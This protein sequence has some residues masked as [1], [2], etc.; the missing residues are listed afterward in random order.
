[1]AGLGQMLALPALAGLLALGLVFFVR[2]GALR[3]SAARRE[4]LQALSWT[5][6]PVAVFAL[7]AIPSLRL[8]ALRDSVPQADLTI[9]ITGTMWSWTYEYPDQN[10]L[11]FTAAMLTIPPPGESAVLREP[12][13][14]VV[15]LGKAV[16]IEAVGT[17]LIYSWA[18]PALGAKVT[19]LPGRTARTWFR[20]QTLGRYFGTCLELCAVPHSFAP[21]EV[22]VVSETRFAD[23]VADA[24]RRYAAA[25]LLTRL[26]RNGP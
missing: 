2:G 5:L 9:R 10:N 19:G 17:N 21:I 1:M 24:R 4:F 7:I 8:V 3:L 26:A 23:W 11:R 20:P 12:E 15:P 13:H 25:A 16:R 14:I 6:A 22:E 18:I